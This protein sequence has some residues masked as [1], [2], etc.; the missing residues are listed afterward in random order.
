M[1]AQAKHRTLTE[2]LLSWWQK[3]GALSEL[4]RRGSEVGHIAQDL[5]VAPGKLRVLAA[6]RPDSAH[7]LYQRLAL[8]QLDA[9][10]MAAADGATLRDLQRLCTACSSKGRCARDL[11]D[12]SPTTGWREYC[13]NARTLDALANEAEGERAIARLER[14]QARAMRIQ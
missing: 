2:T 12:L 11:A 3:R 8:L 1:P 6:K 7:L 9:T 4:E 10:R 5:G 13:P 14:R